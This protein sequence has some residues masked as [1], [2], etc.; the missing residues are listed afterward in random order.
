VLVETLIDLHPL[1]DSSYGTS[2][3]GPTVDG[4]LVKQLPGKALNQDG[5]RVPVM[6]GLTKYD[7]LFY[8]PPW[9]RNNAQL[10]EHALNLF[11]GAPDT[12]LDEI[13]T[14]YPIQEGSSAKYKLLKAASFLDVSQSRIFQ[15]NLY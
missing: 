10:R 15:M 6:V 11:P 9:I 14:R 12:V 5:W 13:K 7:S 1:A 3:F 4:Y 8:T 2:S